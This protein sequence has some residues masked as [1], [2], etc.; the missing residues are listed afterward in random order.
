MAPKISSIGSAGFPEHSH[1]ADANEFVDKL[2]GPMSFFQRLRPG[3]KRASI[4]SI[5]MKLRRRALWTS[6]S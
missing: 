1:S 2:D 6:Q 4:G 3:H 5:V